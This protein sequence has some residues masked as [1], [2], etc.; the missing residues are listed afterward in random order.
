[1]KSSVPN[2][3]AQMGAVT[4]GRPSGLRGF[5]TSRWR[6]EVELGTVFWRDML[7]VGTVINGVTSVAAIALISSGIS[8]LLSAAV[9]FSPLPYNIFIF[10]SVWRAAERSRAQGSLAAKII[11]ALWLTAACLL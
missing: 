7:L 11:A 1:M 8:P 6:G 5:F 10:V 9:F 3:A 2:T 4:G